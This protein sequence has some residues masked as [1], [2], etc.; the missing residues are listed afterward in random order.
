M[1]GA[2]FKLAPDHEQ[3]AM[4][5]DIASARRLAYNAALELTRQTLTPEEEDRLFVDG[6]I[7]LG[8]TES[9]ASVE[10]THR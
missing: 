3:E 10:A 1:R 2:T 8:W 6:L 5:I 9:E 7:S 4:L